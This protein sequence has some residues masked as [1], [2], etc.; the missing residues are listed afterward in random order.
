MLSLNVQIKEIQLLATYCTC[1]LSVQ[2]NW[3][4]DCQ[5][6]F[7]YGMHLSFSSLKLKKDSRTNELIIDSAHLQLLKKK[8]AGLL[9]C[10]LDIFGGN[11]EKV[12]NSIRN[13]HQKKWVTLTSIYFFGAHLNNEQFLNMICISHFHLNL[14]KDSWT[15][16]SAHLQLLKKLLTKKGL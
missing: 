3:Q 15:N 2:S 5:T 13:C 14:K 9:L 6:V 8:A 12:K 1:S 16:D 10:I 4:F 7:K 11:K